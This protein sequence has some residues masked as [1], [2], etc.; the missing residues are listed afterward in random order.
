MPPPRAAG[1]THSTCWPVVAVWPESTLTPV[2]GR[3][4]RVNAGGRL[5]NDEYA[6][7]QPVWLAAV[8]AGTCWKLPPTVLPVGTWTLPPRTIAETSRFRSSR[9]RV[10]LAPDQP[11]QHRRPLRVAD[12]DERP[13]VVVVRR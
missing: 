2:P 13:A 8:Q 5:G 12:Q 1:F 3:P 11:D 9:V 6:I 7:T 4:N 10:D